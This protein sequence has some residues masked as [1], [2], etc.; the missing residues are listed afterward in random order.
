MSTVTNERRTA[1][2]PLHIMHLR[3]APPQY[4]AT[5]SAWAA[6]SL[7][8]PERPLSLSRSV[9]YM[10]YAGCREGEARCGMQG[11]RVVCTDVHMKF[12]LEQ[13]ERM[14]D[15]GA[16]R[17]L[18]RLRSPTYT[19]KR[20]CSSSPPCRLSS[21][22]STS[23]RSPAALCTSFVTARPKGIAA[24]ACVP[25]CLSDTGVDLS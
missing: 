9:L 15:G 24:D 6:R 18:T 1:P 5:T 11:A 25:R 12:E 17:G 4:N 19:S 20:T 21:R 10:R 16:S 23:L 14:L 7:G 22:C 8:Q 3:R 13:G 2:A